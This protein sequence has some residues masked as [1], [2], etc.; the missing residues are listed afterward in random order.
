MSSTAGSDHRPTPAGVT[1]Y[2]RPGCMFCLML[3]R[4]LRKAG[5][6]VA[7]VNIWEAPDAAAFVRRHA[8]GNETVPTV[9]VAGTVL[10]NPRARQ[11]ADLARAAGVPF[12]A[13]GPG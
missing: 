9:D 8:G 10:V 11:V 3:R 4:G 7:E 2:W 12:S 5:V 6:P 1:V 13:P